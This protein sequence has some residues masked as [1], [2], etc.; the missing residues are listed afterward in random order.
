MPQASQAK[1]TDE[2]PHRRLNVVP[3]RICMD[4]VQ[5]QVAVAGQWRCKRGGSSKDHVTG[6]V[7]YVTLCKNKNADGSCSDYMAID[8]EAIAEER[9]RVR[10]HSVYIVIALG[11]LVLLVM[12]LTFPGLPGHS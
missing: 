11:S 12:A 4:C 9:E 10:R 5:H 8:H 2:H 6:E 3:T 1:A 7:T